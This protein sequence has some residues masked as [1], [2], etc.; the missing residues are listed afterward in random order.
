MTKK[1]NLKRRSVEEKLSLNV[2]E[3]DASIHVRSALRAGGPPGDK[4]TINN[5][6]SGAG[7]AGTSGSGHT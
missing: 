2:R 3:R 1:K 6:T 5:G 7:G 4:S